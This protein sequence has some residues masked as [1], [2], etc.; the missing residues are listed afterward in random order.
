MTSAEKSIRRALRV[1]HTLKKHYSLFGGEIFKMLQ[2]H[3]A[4][5]AAFAKQTNPEK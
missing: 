5:S 1:G 2:T 3:F 4:A